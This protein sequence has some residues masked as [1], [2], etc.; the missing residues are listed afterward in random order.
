ME[1]AVFAIHETLEQLKSL[2][3]YRSYEKP[4]R[5][6]LRTLLKTAG[7]LELFPFKRRYFW[8][9]EDAWPCK[10]FW[11]LLSKVG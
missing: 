6:Q 9:Y 3:Q 7:Q 10:V 5:K 1:S 8:V 2:P 4:L 11:W